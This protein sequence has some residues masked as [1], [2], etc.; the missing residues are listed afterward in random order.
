MIARYAPVGRFVSL[1]RLSTKTVGG[2]VRR[3]STG[4]SKPR[5]AFAMS[6]TSPRGGT[7]RTFASAAAAGGDSY[8]VLIYDYVGDILDKRGPHRYAMAL[9]RSARFPLASNRLLTFPFFRF[10]Q[11]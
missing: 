11:R 6:T 5:T 8:S 3:T 7:A 9:F 2:P 4:L 1:A 10:A